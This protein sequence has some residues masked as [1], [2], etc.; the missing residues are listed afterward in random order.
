MK[1]NFELNHRNGGERLPNASVII[2]IPVITA[3]VIHPDKR[4]G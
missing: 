4:R 1:V 2:T 3:L